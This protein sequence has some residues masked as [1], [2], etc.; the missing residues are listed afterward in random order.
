MDLE[1]FTHLEL[2]CILVCYSLRQLAPARKAFT[3]VMCCVWE[4]IHYKCHLTIQNSVLYTSILARAHTQDRPGLIYGWAA[5]GKRIIGVR[6]C[7]RWDT[8]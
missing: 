5:G 7:Y 1:R 6:A 8:W 4:S 2:Y 3:Y